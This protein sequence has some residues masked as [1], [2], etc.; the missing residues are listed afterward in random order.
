[1]HVLL[2]V[3]ACQ[4]EHTVGNLAIAEIAERILPDMQDTRAV[5]SQ[6]IVRRMIESPTILASGYCAIAHDTAWWLQS[7]VDVAWPVAS[8][9]SA[10]P[11]R[12]SVTVTVADHGGNQRGA[13]AG[14]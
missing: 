5:K 3:P 9:V 4:E 1:M 7:A 8:S 12:R 13:S 11:V 10:A 6:Q 2:D 14:S